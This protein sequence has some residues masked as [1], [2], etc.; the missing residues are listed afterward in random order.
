MDQHGSEDC[1]AQRELEAMH[2]IDT[3]GAP[4][5]VAIEEPVER[6]FKDEGGA[7]KVLFFGFELHGEITR[8]LRELADSSSRVQLRCELLYEDMTHVESKDDDGKDMFMVLGGLEPDSDR[9]TLNLTTRSGGV[10]YHINKVSMRRDGKKYRIRVGIK[11]AGNVMWSAIEPVVS[12]P[13]YVASKRSGRN[14]LER[15]D[16]SRRRINR[17]RLRK[18]Q[19]VSNLSRKNKDLV[20]G[21]FK[22]EEGGVGSSTAAGGTHIPLVGMPVP[23]QLQLPPPAATSRRPV[24]KQQAQQQRQQQQRQQQQYVRNGGT[25]NVNARI[26]GKRPI[27]SMVVDRQQAKR[28]KANA[29]DFHTQ[30]PL[31]P[32]TA[33]SHGLLTEIMSTPQQSSSSTNKNKNK[34]GYTSTIIKTTPSVSEL[35]STVDRLLSRMALLEQE[36]R[37][38]WRANNELTTKVTAISR[39]SYSHPIN[40]HQHHSNIMLSS[41]S[42]NDD[43]D[44]EHMHEHSSSSAHERPGSGEHPMMPMLP[45][46]RSWSNDSGRLVSMTGNGT[47]SGNGYDSETAVPIFDMLVGMP[48]G[49]DGGFGNGA[50]I[51]GAGVHAANQSIN[52]NKP[53]MHRPVRQFSL[54][55]LPADAGDPI[56]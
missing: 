3:S 1:A 39:A 5:L 50:G 15:A 7:S 42:E 29:I 12:I 43:D 17:L 38:L 32:P 55:S 52:L 4:R 8:E 18:E 14:K 45:L 46:S 53:P 31:S 22:K 13:T 20:G 56:A 34:S 6:Y 28:T 10:R 21:L 9:P 27:S 51:G 23:A 48:E 16:D 47:G 37:D 35:A 41:D 30:S 54:S 36:N 2:T 11:T 25:G 33:A 44:N 26:G 19:L 49:V 24:A 40:L